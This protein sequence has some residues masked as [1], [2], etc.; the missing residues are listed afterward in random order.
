[1][2]V[3]Y[4]ESATGKLKSRSKALQMQEQIAR[5]CLIGGD[6]HALDF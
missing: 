3:F 5:K 2:F 4:F 1:L 6:F